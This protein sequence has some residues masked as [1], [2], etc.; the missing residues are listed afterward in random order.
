[1]ILQ[2]CFLFV[3]VGSSNVSSSFA[4]AYSSID[5]SS[6]TSIGSLS[7][8]D[9]IAFVRYSSASS[10]FASAPNSSSSIVSLRSSDAISSFSYVDSS[11]AS[12]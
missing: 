7:K 8:F 5:S 2:L 4:S 11:T 3:F 10:S 9:L 12:Y 6:I 1:L